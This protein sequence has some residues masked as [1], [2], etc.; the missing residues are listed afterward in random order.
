MA[1]ER[2]SARTVTATAMPSYPVELPIQYKMLGETQVAGQGRT[3][4]IGS[5]SIR[6]FC[7]RPL[8]LN[9]KIQVV[10]VW[11]ATLPDGTGLN[12]WIE[13]ATL[14]NVLSDVEICVDRYEFR[15]RRAARRAGSPTIVPNLK[16]RSVTGSARR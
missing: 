15:T 4:T 1:K 11:P 5:R 6:L 13:G 3:V 14:R 12:L 9:E 8:P 10:V 2:A 7:D 16:A